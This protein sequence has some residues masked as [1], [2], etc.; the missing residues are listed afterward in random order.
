MAA[1][2]HA[3]TSA[4]AWAASANSD[5][6]RIVKSSGS[7]TPEPMR[8]AQDRPHLLLRR[9]DVGGAQSSPGAG[10]LTGLGA[11][12]TLAFAPYE[13]RESATDAVDR[14][15]R[16]IRVCRWPARAWGLFSTPSR[17][18]RVAGS[19]PR[20]TFECGSQVAGHGPSSR[21]FSRLCSIARTGCHSSATVVARAP[22]TATGAAR[23]RPWQSSSALTAH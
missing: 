11:Q 12:H 17:L 23:R 10:T 3:I 7:A 13:V 16:R 20:L 9:R 14:R 18:W 19:H 15:R 22:P 21:H 2:S 5:R 6:L 8:L 4:V 1:S